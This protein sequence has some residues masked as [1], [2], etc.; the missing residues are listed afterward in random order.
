M[1]IEPVINL[2]PRV[3]FFKLQILAEIAKSGSMKNLPEKKPKYVEWLQMYF[4]YIK[5][6]WSL[7][8]SFNSTFN[9]SNLNK[10]FINRCVI[11]DFSIMKPFP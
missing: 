5:F 9:I 1:A 4:V 8:A 7:I 10:R 6:K 3:V 11:K 2:K